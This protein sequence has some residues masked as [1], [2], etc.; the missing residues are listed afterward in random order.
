MLYLLNAF[1]FN[2]IGEFP[3]EVS[4]TEITAVT[5]RDLLVAEVAEVGEFVK[6]ND[7]SAVVIPAIGHA[8]TAAVFGAVLDLNVP[9][10]RINVTLKKWDKAV[11]GQY[12][13]PR[14]PEGATTLPEGA[15]IKWL[16]IEVK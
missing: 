9:C 5:A 2:M 4:A 10:N 15:T 11:I 12:T 7:I 8:D 6:A 13:G 1:S 3:V 16:L 14:L